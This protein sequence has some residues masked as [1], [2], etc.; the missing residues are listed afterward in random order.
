MAVRKRKSALPAVRRTMQS[1]GSRIE[2][3]KF[4]R[5]QGEGDFVPLNYD[6]TS[7]TWPENGW[8]HR[9]TSR[10]GYDRNSGILRIQFYTNGAIYDYGTVTPVPPDVA[11]RFRRVDSPG[12][13]INS[14]LEGYGY[15]RVA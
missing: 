1:L 13:F 15:E 2:A 10:A 3:E 4:A 7:T 5:G 9:R 6:P 8:D 14:A 11:K 12:K